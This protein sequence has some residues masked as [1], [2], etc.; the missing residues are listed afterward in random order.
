MNE[1]LQYAS[2]L[3]IPVSTSSVS[4][5]TKKKKS[6]KKKKVNDELIKAELLRKVNSEQDLNENFCENS[7]S[8]IALD[9]QTELT[10]SGEQE[11]GQEMALEQNTSNVYM[12]KIKRK[13]SPFKF[14]VVGLQLVIIG[15]LVATIFLTNALYKDS[16]IN[17][18]LRGVFGTESAAIDTREYNEFSPVISMG[19]NS[20]VMMSEGM[21]TFAGEG[22]VYAP[23]DGIVK[24]ISVSENG[25]YNIEIEHS[26]NFKS[27]ISDVERV[28]VSEG[29]TVY[30][31]IPLGY[32]EA[33]GASICFTNSQGELLDDYEMV[34]NMVVW[35]E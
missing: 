14:T 24:K 10:L 16:G 32:L 13:K 17:V 12:S 21:I 33:D 2:M 1:K 35:Q 19:D 9:N 8:L 7:T 18:F 15:V 23:C 34:D 25:R 4:A 30:G 27:I 11:L 6:R 3:D 28:Y 29:D 22:S 31:N 5:I 26:Q 20:G